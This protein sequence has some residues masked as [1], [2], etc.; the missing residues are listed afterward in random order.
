MNFDNLHQV[1]GDFVWVQ[2]FK[3]ENKVMNQVIT[4]WMLSSKLYLYSGAPFSVTDS[5]IG[6]QV[7]SRP[8]VSSTRLLTC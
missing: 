3:V 2:P 8:E 4:G 6:P 1:A 5:K 7:N